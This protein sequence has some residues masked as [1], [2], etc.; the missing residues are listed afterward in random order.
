ML[1]IKK[2]EKRRQ[3]SMATNVYRIDILCNPFDSRQPEV[4]IKQK[5]QTI[6]CSYIS[7]IIHALKTNENERG[8]NNETLKN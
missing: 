8:N 2:K 3:T 5:Y 4:T 6:L 7:Y 1:T